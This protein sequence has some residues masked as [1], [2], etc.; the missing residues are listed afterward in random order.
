MKQEQIAGRITAIARDYL[1]GLDPQ[2]APEI[3]PETRLFG[4]SGV[5]DSLGLV[6]VVLEVEQQIGDETGVTISLMDDKAMSQT[7][8]PFRTVSSLAEYVAAQ[9]TD[10]GATDASDAAVLGGD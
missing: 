7:R 3:G 1:R 9:L 8:S 2:A 10:Q 6:N 4:R 5:L